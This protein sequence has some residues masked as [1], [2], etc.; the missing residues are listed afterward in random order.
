MFLG[1][2]EDGS[3]SATKKAQPAGSIRGRLRLECVD[4]VFAAGPARAIYRAG[5]TLTDVVGTVD[6]R[7]LVS[8]FSV[9]GTDRPPVTGD[10][11]PEW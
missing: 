5:R 7:L 6:Y 8:R 4:A 1:A 3:P 11:A 2:R 9:S 10:C